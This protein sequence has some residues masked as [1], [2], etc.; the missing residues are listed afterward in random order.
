MKLYK[1]DSESKIFR[2][3][4]DMRMII[5]S[6]IVLFSV[7]TYLITIV[8][9]YKD[10][11][12]NPIMNES[13]LNDFIPLTNE[14][15]NPTKDRHWKDSTFND[16]KRRADIY[17]SRG[18]FKGTPL[19]GELL[20]LCARNT[21]DSTNILVPVE[22]ALLQAQFESSMGRDGRSPVNNPFNLNEPSS[23]T[24]KWYKSTFD[25]TQAYYYCMANTYLKCK[26]TEQLLIDFVNCS[27]KRYAEQPTYEIALASEYIRIKKWIDFNIIK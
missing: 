15:L 17:L 26:T 11:I 12:K 2:K 21:Y 6:Y 20:A 14:K 10:I 22:L 18:V 25:G 9:N 16:Y 13:S 8:N 24:T 4:I 7:I 3:I 23:G 19:T 27:G 1:F 5:L